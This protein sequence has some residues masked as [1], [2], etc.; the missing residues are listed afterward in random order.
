[1][2]STNKKLIIY[3]F[4]EHQLLRKIKNLEEALKAQEFSSNV[5]ITRLDMKNFWLWTW[6]GIT[7]FLAML[8]TFVLLLN[9]R[10][11]G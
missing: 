4:K 9:W 5:K 8:E 2:L 10:G 1:M 7:G 3:D 6:A 11:L